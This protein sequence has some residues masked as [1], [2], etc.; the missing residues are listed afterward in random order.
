MNFFLLFIFLYIIL[1][2]RLKVLS[3]LI[4]SEELLSRYP[5][6]FWEVFCQSVSL[7]GV[8][9]AHTSFV[10]VSRYLDVFAQVSRYLGKE[11]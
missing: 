8:S 2:F 6:P 1:R 7:K 10:C 5:G 9:K 3:G 11:R 4:R